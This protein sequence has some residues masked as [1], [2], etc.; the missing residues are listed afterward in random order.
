M[1]NIRILVQR[2]LTGFSREPL[3]ILVG[4]IYDHVDIAYSFTAFRLICMTGLIV[5]A[6]KINRL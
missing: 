6:G 3:V 4:K 5:Y 1:P 2:L